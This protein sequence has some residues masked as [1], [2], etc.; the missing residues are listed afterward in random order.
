MTLLEKL[1]ANLA[2]AKAI[3]AA[4]ETEN[5]EYTEA[6]A[7]ELEGIAAE[8]DTLQ[9]QIDLDKKLAGYDA[10]INQ[11]MGRQTSPETPSGGNQKPRK[12]SQED[13]NGFAS[14]GEYF[15]AVR[16]AASG[17][18]DQRLL[19]AA[20]NVIGGNGGEEGFSLPPAIRNEIFTVLEEDVGDMLSRVNSEI[21]GS[22]SVSYLKDVST[23]WEAA[24]IQVHWD[25]G[26]KKFEPTAYNALTA[27]QLTLNGLS[28]FCNVDE[29]L[30][31]DAPRLG[32]RLMSMAP[33]AM[34]WTINEAIRYGDGVGKPK[35][36]MQSKAVITVAKEP[37]Q[38]K[39]TLTA[40][41]IANMYTRMLPSSLKN[42]HWEVSQELLPQLMLLKDEDGN[43]LW[44]PNNTGFVGAPAGTLLG[45]PVIF[46]EHPEAIGSRGDIQFVDPSG[47]YLAM[48]TAS[49]KFSES[50]H[51]YFDQ[52][53]QSF[54]WRLRL[55][56][57]PVLSKPVEP[58]KGTLTKSH[59]V[60]LAARA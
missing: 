51:I 21:T 11:T 36:Y 30:L 1:K 41:N 12:Q 9:K 7:T 40:A 17:D 24:G 4:A 10:S 19:A 52:G 27:G 58:A 47:Y 6:E 55:D 3:K 54:R 39:G 53:L 60:T 34:R 23:P 59:F 49:A 44:T 28:V 14:A 35:G 22:S 8:C 5:R 13:L 15:R 50:M 37:S 57:S 31:E 18:I 2:R 33:I 56:G 46:N 26:G 45:R 32:Q 29:D 43:L 20:G 42:A 16:M 38:A 25:Q 48:R